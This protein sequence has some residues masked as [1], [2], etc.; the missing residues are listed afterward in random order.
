[1][2]D[3]VTERLVELAE[4]AQGSGP[5][6]LP[7]GDYRAPA[8]PQRRMALSFHAYRP[9]GRDS[10]CR[11]WGRAHHRLAGRLRQQAAAFLRAA[12]AWL[13]ARP[14]PGRRQ[15]AAT[16]VIAAVNYFGAVSMATLVFLG[17]GAFGVLIAMLA[18]F[19]G[20]FDTVTVSVSIEAVAGFIG[21]L[22][23]GAAV[24]NEYL[25]RQT[26]VFGALG[27][28]IIVAV[29]AAS[30]WR[31]AWSPGVKRHAD[32]RHPDRVATSSGAKG[33]VVSQIPAGGYGEVR[34]RI[35]GQPL[36]LMP[37]PT[38]PS[39]SARRCVVHRRAQ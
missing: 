1:M 38:K 9:V 31:C 30:S 26:V 7:V 37:V 35:G 36:K 4:E 22:G 18:M 2:A 23:F 11:P 6:T 25:R 32:R 33:V 20:S 12:I 27:V 16:N 19:G 14:G 28:G 5:P 17:I 24:A 8:S 29:F 21:G 15:P 10:A 39:V 13:T 34:V 3:G